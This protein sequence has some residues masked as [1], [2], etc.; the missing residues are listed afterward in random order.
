MN[1]KYLRYLTLALCLTLVVTQVYAVLGATINIIHSNWNLTAWGH[2]WW[3]PAPSWTKTSSSCRAKYHHFFANGWA[4]A[5]TVDIWMPG[6][7]YY[8]FNLKSDGGTQDYDS[9]QIT[10][11]FYN[12]NGQQIGSNARYSYGLL[13]GPIPVNTVKCKLEVKYHFVTGLD[14]DEAGFDPR[15]TLSLW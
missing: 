6:Y 9:I 4:K 1:K 11:R 12:S 13:S 15:V 2:T 7:N 10:I 14:Y 8:S 5:L 3:D